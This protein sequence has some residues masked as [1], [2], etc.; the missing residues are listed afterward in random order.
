MPLWH[1]YRA[2]VQAMLMALQE[3]SSGMVKAGQQ[4]VVVAL[5]RSGGYKLEGVWTAMIKAAL[6]E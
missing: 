5:H 3:P 4:E 2:E 6:A 1:D